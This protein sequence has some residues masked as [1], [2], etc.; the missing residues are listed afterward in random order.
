[1]LLLVCISLREKLKEN[2]RLVHRPLCF[3]YKANMY[4]LK[5]IQQIA[6]ICF[7]YISQFFTLMSLYN[8]CVSIPTK[9]PG[10]AVLFRKT[11]FENF[12]LFFLSC[13]KS[14]IELKWHLTSSLDNTENEN[15]ERWDFRAKI[16]KWDLAWEHELNDI[17]FIRFLSLTQNTIAMRM[18]WCF[19]FNWFSF[20]V[21]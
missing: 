4:F 14:Q 11:Y 18:N 5:Q 1:M 13:I 20:L 2:T 17:N 9:L 7:L 10:R 21:S 3:E 12:V 19:R 8:V 15:E 16:F 6:V